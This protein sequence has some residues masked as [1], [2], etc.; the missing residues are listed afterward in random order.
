MDWPGLPLTSVSPPCTSHAPNYKQLKHHL[1]PRLR[2]R[3]HLHEDHHHRGLDQLEVNTFSTQQ[4]FS[5][6]NLSVAL[7]QTSTLQQQQNIPF[8]LKI[9]FLQPLDS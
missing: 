5:H 7:F 9:V 2:L 6:L 4:L 1:H 3:L 8:L